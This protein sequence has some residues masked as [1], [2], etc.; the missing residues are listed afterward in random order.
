MGGFTGID[1]ALAGLIG[2]FLIP[3]GKYLLPD[4]PDEL[5]TSSA[6]IISAVII[7][8]AKNKQ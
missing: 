6:A 1:K 8:F 7:F 4:A 5:I 3:L 2:P